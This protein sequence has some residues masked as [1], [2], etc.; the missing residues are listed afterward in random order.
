MAWLDFSV[1]NFTDTEPQQLMQK[2][3]KVALED[4]CIFVLGE[5]ISKELIL[6]DLKLFLEK[7]LKN[8]EKSLEDIAF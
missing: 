2:K 6:H 1:Y 5:N 3:A 7:S 4:G 8:I